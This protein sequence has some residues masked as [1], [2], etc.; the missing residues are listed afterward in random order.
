MLPAKL[1]CILGLYSG[2]QSGIGPVYMSSSE[3][4]HSFGVSMHVIVSLVGEMLN[5]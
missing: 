1:I 2:L 5:P 4:M 3:L